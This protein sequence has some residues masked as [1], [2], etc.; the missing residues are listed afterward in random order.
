MPALCSYS[1]RRLSSRTFSQTC[2]KSIHGGCRKSP[3]GYVFF[4]YSSLMSRGYCARKGF[5]NTLHGGS[6]S[7]SMLTKVGE[8]SLGLK[9][10]RVNLRYF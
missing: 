6:E 7:A 4:L 10:L 5:Y 9:L 1:W 8:K 2:H 3:I